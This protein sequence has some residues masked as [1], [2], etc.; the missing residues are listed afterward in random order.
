MNKL[1]TTDNGGFPFVLDDIRWIDNAVRE[2]FKGLVSSL[3]ITATESFKISGCVVSN[4]GSVYS[5]TGGYICLMGEIMKVEAGSVTTPMQPWQQNYGLYWQLDV[6]Y[7]ATG[8]KIFE[9]GISYDTYEIRKGKLVYGVYP[10]SQNGGIDYMPHNAKYMHTK[11]LELLTSQEILSKIITSE[12]SEKLLNSEENWKKAILLNNYSN[13]GS[14]FA[15]VSYKKDM[16]NMIHIKGLATKAT[17]DYM[18]IFNLPIGY[19]P[20]EE[21]NIGDIKI[22]SN[23]DVIS[24]MNTSSIKLELSFKI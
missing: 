5:W 17:P 23:G 9:S 1:K 3:G 2:S 7:D 8:V 20:A 6:I 18:A 21:R 19:R 15:E 22:K 24:Y 16:L 11:L 14:P 12:L 13:Q 4:V 10:T